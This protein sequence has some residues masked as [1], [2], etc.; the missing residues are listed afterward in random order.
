MPAVDVIL[1]SID[2]HEKSRSPQ[3]NINLMA[4]QS[5]VIVELKEKIN[6]LENVVEDKD[7]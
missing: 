6:M 4:G 1:R 3:N 7:S 5:G 2:R